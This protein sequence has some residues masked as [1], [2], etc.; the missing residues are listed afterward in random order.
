M[1]PLTALQR[2]TALAFTK[3]EYSTAL[4]PP[5]LPLTAMAALSCLKVLDLSA[6]DRLADAGEHSFI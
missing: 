6:C 1:Q 3:C 5:A 4:E 2:L